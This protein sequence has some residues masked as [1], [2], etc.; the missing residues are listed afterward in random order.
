MSHHLYHLDGH[1]CLLYHPSYVRSCGSDLGNWECLPLPH[2]GGLCPRSCWFLSRSSHRYLYGNR[3]S[4]S[5]HGFCDHGYRPSDIQLSSDVPL[6]G[7]HWDLQFAILLFFCE[8]KGEGLICPSMSTDV[9]IVGGS[10]N[11]F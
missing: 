9:K 7:S 3:R 4:G 10:L 8:K 2:L 1:P 6:L 5:G 11:F